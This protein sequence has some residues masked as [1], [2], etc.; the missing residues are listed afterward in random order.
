MQ[1]TIYTTP[2]VFDA[3]AGEWNALVERSITNT[4]FLT[5]EWQKTWWRD[6]GEGELRV[7]A[8]RDPAAGRRSSS[9]DSAG[10]LIGIAPLFFEANQLGGVEVALVGCK[11]VSD[12]LDFIFAKGYE[13]A[14]FREVIAYLKSNDAPERHTIGLCNIIESS[15]T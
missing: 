1:T 12:Y 8:M 7:L 6:L 13:E 4:L 2:E 15:P 11:E 5:D 10:A 3:L 14:C 9:D